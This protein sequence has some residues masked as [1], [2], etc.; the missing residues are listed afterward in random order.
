MTLIDWLPSIGTLFTGIVV[1]VSSALLTVRLALRRFYS[2]KWWER[3]A[4]AYSAI[5]EALHHVRN[6]TD[7]NLDALKRG[8]NLPPDGDKELT[9]KLQNAM[10]ELRKR[11][12][13]GSFVISNEAVETMNI[14]MQELTDSTKSKNL[15]A[16]LLMKME[17]VNKCLDSMRTIAR[18]DLSLD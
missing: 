17:A 2:E 7:H 11:S 12:D 5:L 13:I 4:E 3:K 6:Y 16:H 8:M 9:N 15:D 18:N 10:A 1:A 14:F